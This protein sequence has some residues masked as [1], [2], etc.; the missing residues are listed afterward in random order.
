MGTKCRKISQIMSMPKPGLDFSTTQF[1]APEVV[2]DIDNNDHNITL[3]TGG[4][5]PAE[6]FSILCVFLRFYK[7]A[8]KF[9]LPLANSK[10]TAAGI[11]DIS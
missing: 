4:A 6:G 3:D 2:I 10:Y 5:V 8:D 9:T 7:V 1:F 11:V